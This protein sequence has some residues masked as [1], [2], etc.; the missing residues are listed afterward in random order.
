MWL[1]KHAKDT[2]L[3]L[4][5]LGQSARRS[6]QTENSQV[7]TLCACCCYSA[8]CALGHVVIQ[9]V[10]MMSKQ[11][12]GAGSPVTGE[13]LQTQQTPFR[14]VLEEFLLCSDFASKEMKV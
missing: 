10:A 13:Y 9:D 6:S 14:L 3:S 2:S 4:Q 11:A 5:K 1:H 12:G 7:Y 8:A